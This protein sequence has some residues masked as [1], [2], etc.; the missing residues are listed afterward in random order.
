VRR[1]TFRRATLRNVIL[2]N[3]RVHT[4]DD[5]WPTVSAL[6]IRGDRIAA[7][8]SGPSVIGVERV[9][10]HGLCV[11]PGFS[12]AH[13]HFPTWSLA[14]REVRLDGARSL[15][16]AV[17]RVAAGGGRGS[18]T[19]WIRGRGW[20]SGDWQPQVEPMREDLDAVSR[21]VPIALMAQ[22][23]H[24][25]WLNSA[26][27]ARAN[28]DLHVADGV[29]ELDSDGE[30]SGVLREE[31]AWYFRDRYLQTPLSGYVDAM[32]EGMAVA[33]ARG[34]TAIHDK[35]GWIGA[36]AICSRSCATRTR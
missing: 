28:G 31:A 32:R 13:V 7:L 25:L 4:M 27:L 14:R 18:S 19:G 34:V 10:L 3:A 8:G 17:A 29:V 11:L 16:E 22:D 30:P 36:L 20:R 9:D 5:A 2:E 24:S 26:G 15:E 35:D 21:D 6:A 33:H 12:D 1:V 23:G